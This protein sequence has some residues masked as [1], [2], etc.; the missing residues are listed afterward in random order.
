MHTHRILL[1]FKRGGGNLKCAVGVS[2]PCGHS[3]QRSQAAPGQ[4]LQF[5]FPEVFGAERQR[6]RDS[7]RQSRLAAAVW[8]EV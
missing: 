3:A 5:H 1:D 7:E 2:E 4:S 6:Q 8:V